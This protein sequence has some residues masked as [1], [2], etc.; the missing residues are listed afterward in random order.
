MGT[1]GE[2]RWGGK[3]KGEKWKKIYRSIKKSIF[4]KAKNVLKKEF[5]SRKVTLGY[6]E[7]KFKTEDNLRICVY[8]F[9]HQII[10]E[11]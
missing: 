5:V 9:L 6:L 2:G 3:K 10:L 11:S 1:L 8:L 7:L 4:N